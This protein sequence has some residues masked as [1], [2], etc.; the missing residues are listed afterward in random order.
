MRNRYLF[1]LDFVL[2]ALTPILAMVLRLDSAAWVAS[3]VPALIRFTVLALGVKLLTFFMFGLYRRFWRYASIDELVSIFLA[4]GSATLVVAGLF[5]GAGILRL[6]ILGLDVGRSLPRSVPF[7][8][9]LLTLLVVGGSRFSVRVAAHKRRRVDH[10]D[11]SKAV[12]IVGAG[13]AGSMI[14]RE[15]LSSRHINF[16]PVGFVDDDPAKRNKSIHG[17]PVL[18]TRKDIPRLT[19][20]H[21]VDEVVIAIPTAPGKVIREIMTLCEAARVPSRTMPG[22]YEILSGQ[23][24]VAQLR[25]VDIEDL[26]RRDPIRIDAQEVGKMLSGKRVLVTGAGG[27]IGSELCRQ[28]ARSAP[29]RLALLGHG[30]NSLFAF[31]NEMRSRWPKLPISVFVADIRDQARLNAIF[32]NLKPQVVFH[33]AA[34][35][36]VPM[37]ESNCE[38]AVTN[39][40]GGTRALAQL[41]ERFGVERFVLISSDKAVNPTNIMGVTKR[42][43]EKIV[44]SVARRTGRPYV[45]VRFGNVLGSRGSVVPT[46]REQIARGGPVTITHPDVKRYFMTI[47]EAVQ[48]VLQAAT[49]AGVECR[50]GVFVLDMGEPIKIVDLARDLIELSGKQVGQDIEIVFTGLRP[51]EKLFEE[52]FRDGE[53]YHRTRHEKIFVA[54]G[55]PM[56]VA[57]SVP[58]GKTEDDNLNGLVDQLIRQAELGCPDDIR[59]LLKEIVPNYKPAVT[60]PGLPKSKREA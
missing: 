59:R 21:G 47:P 19:A 1:L 8:D 57:T 36:H 43:A 16:D 11:K 39:N 27:S 41:A 15:M 3:Y 25:N 22:M 34:H 38:D 35:K 45:A 5:F 55:D 17:L 58:D 49:L 29:G 14:V 9:G 20:K 2:L 50:N 56:D 7:I 30:E 37:M 44:Q 46:F 52:L 10:K 18:G 24:S 40:V 31:E 48:L 51:G 13:D 28:I 53:N 42:V 23:V 32:E 6:D 54:D 33:A 12:L 26:L 60:E 4:V